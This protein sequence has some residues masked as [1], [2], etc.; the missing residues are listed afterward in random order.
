MNKKFL[1]LVFLFSGFLVSQNQKKEMFVKYTDEKIIIDGLLEESDW[2]KTIPASGFFEHFPNHG[3]DKKNKA[4]IRV[5]NNDEFLYVGI[6]IFVNSSR[7]KNDSFRRDFQ[8]GNSDNV[9]LIF[10]TFNDGNNA[11][12]I[13]S[14]HIGIQRDML[15]SNGG[16]GL[17][18]FDM[19]W[20]INWE[21][22]SKIYEDYYITEWK[23]PLSSLKYKEGEI[24]WGFNS[25]IRN[26]E[27][28]SW[29]VWNLAP[30]NEMFFNLAFTGDMYFEKPLVKS[31]SKK[32]IIPYINTISFKDFD[33]KSSGNNFEFGSDAKLIFDNSLTLDM[34][35]NPDFSQVEV[36]E[37]ITNLTRFEISLPEKRQFFIENSDI[38][39]RLGNGR[40]A[41]PFFSRRIGIAKDINGNNIQNKIIAGLRLTGKINNNLRIG[42]LNMQTSSDSNNE[43]SA[44][45]NSM[46]SIQQK[47]FAR[48]NFSVF[49]INRDATG[50]SDFLNE[51]DKFNRVI[52]F[53]YDLR[54]NNSKWDGK[55]Y[56]HKSF[57]PENNEDNDSYGFSTTY[58]S[59][60]ISFR[61]AGLYVG[62]DFRSDLGYI[63]RNDISKFYPEIRYTFWPKA[64]NLIN[65]SFEF[66]PVYIFKPNSNYKVSDYY[67]ISKWDAEFRN[68][69]RI[70]LTM[71]NRYTYLFDNFNPTGASE[72]IPLPANSEYYY[73]S[74]DL[75]YS[76]NYSK[77]FTFK[78]NPS[79]GKFY[80]GFKKSLDIELSL[81]IRPQFTSSI[82][83]EYDNVSLPEPFSSAKLFLFSPRMEFTFSKKLYLASLIQYSNQSRNLSLNTR[84]QWRFAPLSD[85]FLVYNDNYFAEERYHS[86]FIPRVK[87]R[88]INFKITYWLDY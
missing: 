18:D 26:T 74:F 40:E 2:E 66:T 78:I 39:S 21:S 70:N 44:Y 37:Q 59:R 52:G 29:I 53:D 25:Y 60:N 35:V 42:V 67:I 23:I 15:L 72:G 8:A 4:T 80:N 86:I 64:S 41:R 3:N 24:K 49:F 79:Y 48:S 10:D 28:N 56:F 20:D 33:D 77:D 50:N 54:S 82:E 22:E 65:H 5:M 62:E 81:R 9:T 14:N 17:R 85:L 83:I 71:W 34:T 76:S 61:L 6:K 19:T 51:N 63:K 43:I 58:E 12:V 38:F 31:K 7:L 57:S 30:E 13:G 84:L 75:S 16:G 36:D 1:G 47:F 68:S 88:S 46:I 32:S 69:S 73:T 27:N 55:Y 11:F 87:N 45:N